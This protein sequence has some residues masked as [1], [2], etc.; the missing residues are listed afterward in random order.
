M[1]TNLRD[2]EYIE[3]YTGK[4]FYFLNPSPDMIDIEDIAHALSHN[5]RYTGHCAEFYSVSEHSYEVS[6]FVPTHLRMQGLLHDASEAYLTDVASPIKPFLHNY[7]ELEEKIMNA[8]AEK[9]EFEWPV[10]PEVKE[11]DVLLLSCEANLLLPSKGNDWAWNVW[12]PTGKRPHT[13]IGAL[14]CWSPKDA[15]VNFLER[16]YEIL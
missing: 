15:K 8:I 4:K 1:E 7:K 2:T 5:C 9:F 12:S 3:T 14:N 10:S 13:Y 6:H 11:A 16:Y